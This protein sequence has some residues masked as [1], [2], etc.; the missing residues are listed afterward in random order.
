M[1]ILKKL[2]HAA[3]TFS[4]YKYEFLTKNATTKCLVKI[5]LFVGSS[6]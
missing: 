5:S 4:I 2:D 1:Q 6:A 3:V